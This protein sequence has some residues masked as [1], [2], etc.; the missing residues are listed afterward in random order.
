MRC[1]PG[2]YSSVNG[3]ESHSKSLSLSIYTSIFVSVCVSTSIITNYDRC[4]KMQGTMRIYGR[5]TNLIQGAGDKNRVWGKQIS[6]ES[7]RP[8]RG[9]S[10]WPGEVLAPKVFPRGA[11]TQCDPHM[12]EDHEFIWSLRPSCLC[13]KPPP[14]P[15]AC[16]DFL[17]IESLLLVHPFLPF[18]CHLP[19]PSLYSEETKKIQWQCWGW[20]HWEAP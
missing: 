18:S 11:G 16:A 20:S 10:Q 6:L 19:I 12:L 2:T 14:P 17:V 9:T 5:G 8:W 15:H 7:V 1:S 3:T 4:L 13:Q